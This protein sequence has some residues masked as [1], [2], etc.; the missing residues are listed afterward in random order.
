[1]ADKKSTV[2]LCLP[3]APHLRRFSCCTERAKKGQRP[4][5]FERGV[6]SGARNHLDS[7]SFKR[8]TRADADKRASIQPIPRLFSLW[9]WTKATTSE[10]R[11]V[12]QAL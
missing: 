7:D 3:K 5:D 11:C 2:A 10:S 12:E 8:P 9:S 4:A 1:M 6:K